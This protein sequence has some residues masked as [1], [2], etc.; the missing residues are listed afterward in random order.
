MKYPITIMILTVVAM[1]SLSI[2]MFGI[3]LSDLSV[4]GDVIKCGEN[5][6]LVIYDG[7]YSEIVW[8][9]R[10]YDDG[11]VYYICADTHQNNPYYK[12]GTNITRLEFQGLNTF[13]INNETKFNHGSDVV[14]KM[15]PDDAQPRYYIE[16]ISE[17][18]CMGGVVIGVDETCK[19]VIRTITHIFITQDDKNDLSVDGVFDW[20]VGY[21]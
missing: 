17:T 3:S 11:Y 10:E 12:N 21:I 18:S 13:L 14:I 4:S 7:E 19:T 8:D 15:I 20:D 9:V 1:S 2:M 6:T 16:P 5:Q